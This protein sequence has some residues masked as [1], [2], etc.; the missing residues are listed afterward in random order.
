M[1][2]LASLLALLQGTGGWTAAPTAP[3]VGDTIWLSRLVAVDAAWRVRAGRL[4][5]TQDAEP[6]G[7][8]V[9]VRAAGGWLVRYPVVMWTPGRHDLTLPPVWRLGPAGQ[10]DSVLGGIASVQV[11]SVLPARDSARGPDPKPAL[12][13]LTRSDNSALPVAGAVAVAGLLLAAGVMLRRRRPR[14]LPA[15]APITR[16]ADVADAH[17][18]AAGEPKAVAARAAARLR[19]AVAGAVP[20]AHPALSTD[21]CLATVAERAPKAPLRD[22]REVL[23]AL[24]QV[25]FA[26]AH[27]ADV[28]A[29]AERARRLV[30]ALSR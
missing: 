15:P 23:T 13:P 1:I 30:A 20:E 24:D 12:D 5:A 21:E 19:A 27:G 16:E 28:G 22:L 3:T 14:D 10:A 4:D 29:L 11:R 17:W 25:G 18:L 26:T 2:A 7:E 8:A 6:I 9:V